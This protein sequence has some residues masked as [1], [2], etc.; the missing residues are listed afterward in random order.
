MRRCYVARDEADGFDKI[1]GEFVKRWLALMVFIAGCET[2]HSR[3][4]DFLQNEMYEDAERTYLEILKED[5]NDTKAVIG[6]A[7]ARQGILDKGLIEVR[8]LRLGGNRQTALEK[9]EY[10]LRK[11]RE[12]TLSLSGAIAVTQRT[13]S[14]D[15]R[16]FL[17]SQLEG[18]LREKSFDKAALRLER[19]RSVAA[20]DDTGAMYAEER[21]A[22]QE[23][24]KEKC[25]RLAADVGGQRFFLRD[26]VAQYCG[27]YGEVVA[28]SLDATDRERYQTLAVT[29]DIQNTGK[30]PKGKVRWSGL[31]ATLNK[32]F[33]QSLWYSPSGNPALAMGVKGKFN[34]RYKLTSE[35][36]VKRY[37]HCW[38][39]SRAQRVKDAKGKAQ[40]KVV[41][42]ER[43]RDQVYFY[44]IYHHRQDFELDVSATGGLSD[45]E[46]VAN[47]SKT[48]SHEDTSWDSTNSEAGIYPREANLVDAR[49][50]ARDM[51]NPMTAAV[52][53]RLSERWV[54]R[55]C[56]GSGDIQD[57]LTVAERAL[58]C[59]KA[60]PTHATANQWVRQRFG[61]SY[62]ELMEVIASET[63]SDAVR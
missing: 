5:K 11:E 25:H 49:E 21:K 42:V 34:Y 31:P 29:L 38:K 22:I 52:M 18:D 39:E 6:L 1:I 35:P 59:G 16:E 56:E 24:S 7:K 62:E 20:T 9:L 60:K 26:L 58:R 27:K 12:W 55:Y 37:Q 53:E 51:L 50:W 57:P 15:S 63:G 48:D 19:F 13:E 23:A 47:F 44:T 46:V 32:A 43:C 41:Q 36:V 61:V 45:G 14:A 2:M 17:K 30:A 10:L 54:M 28:L 3:G 4:K 40:S 33:T 8:M